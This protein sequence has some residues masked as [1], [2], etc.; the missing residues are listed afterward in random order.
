MAIR[1]FDDPAAMRGWA[2]CRLAP[3]DA[4]TDAE[5][6]PKNAV[7]VGH[8]CKATVQCDVDHAGRFERQ[9]HRS[10]AQ[11]CSQDILVRSQASQPLECAQKVVRAEPG[12]FCKAREGQSSVRMALD[13]AYDPSDSGNRGGRSSGHA[14]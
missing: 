13:L 6:R 1:W 11:S 8:I 14:S 5:L 2:E 3:V 7:E 10:F 9:Q 4:R 12:L